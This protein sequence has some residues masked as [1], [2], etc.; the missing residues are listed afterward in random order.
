MRLVRWLV[1][2]GTVPRSVGWVPLP[3]AGGAGEGPGVAGLVGVVAGAQPRELIQ[4][5]VVGAMPVGDVVDLQAVTG[6]TPRHLAVIAARFQ[7][8]ALPC[9][10][11]AAE[12]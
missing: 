12:V 9:G 6:G 11:L 3:G 8:A 10:G 4:A 5:G 2:R 1:S 7:G